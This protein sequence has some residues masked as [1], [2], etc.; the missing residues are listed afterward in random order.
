MVGERL[1]QHVVDGAQVVL[2]VGVDEPEPHTAVAP[3]AG[4]TAPGR[5]R[6]RSPAATSAT[7][8]R[9]RSKPDAR[10]P[11][12]LPLVVGERAGVDLLHLEP[13]SGTD[14][15][16]LA[17]PPTRPG[18][19]SRPGRPSRP[20]RARRRARTASGRP[21]GRGRSP[22]P[23]PRPP[24]RG[25]RRSAGSAAPRSEISTSTSSRS[26]SGPAAAPPLVVAQQ[27]GQPLDVRHRRG[28]ATSTTHPSGSPATSSGSTSSSGSDS[29]LDSPSFTPPSSTL[30]RLNS[31]GGSSHEPK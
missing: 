13:A 26:G 9:T 14:L 21:R 30:T 15:A 10:Q 22:T 27:R 7:S 2:D 19:R 8:V 5:P 1:L 6:R 12:V 31:S 17:R 11:P 18:R 24:R 20:G 3:V 16:G 23:G 29:N 28:P 25:P 4:E